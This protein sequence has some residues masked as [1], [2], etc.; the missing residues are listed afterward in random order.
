MDW[1]KPFD[2]NR[3]GRES[4]FSVVV[5]LVVVGKWRRR[6]LMGEE[7]VERLWRRMEERKRERLRGVVR[8]EVVTPREEM[9]LARSTMG[10]WWPGDM[11]GKKNIWSFS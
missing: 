10:I 8:M 1:V 9:S 11:K 3:E 2:W 7:E 4:R 6:R 5:V